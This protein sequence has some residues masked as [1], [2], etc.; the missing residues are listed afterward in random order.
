VNGVALTLARLVT[1]LRSANHDVQLVRLR[2]GDAETAGQ[3][4][5][6]DSLQPSSTRS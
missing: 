4:A 6:Q 1:G 3:T 5:K 2:Q